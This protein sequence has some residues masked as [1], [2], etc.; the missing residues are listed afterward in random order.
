[1][2]RALTQ[3][4]FSFDGEFFQ[5]PRTCIRPRPRTADLTA[6]MMMAWAS[7]DSLAM[8]ARAGMAPLFTSLHGEESLREGVEA[9]N[10]IRVENGWAPTPSAAN[11][12]VFC[13]EDQEYAQEY[14][15]RFWRSMSGQTIWHYDHL[16]RADWMPGA[17]AEEREALIDQA[18]KAQ[19]AAGIF[20]TPEFVIERIREVQQAGNI[21]HLIT[22]HSFGDMPRDDVERSMRLFAREVLPVIKQIPTQEPSAIPYA[23]WQHSVATAR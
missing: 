1:V 3:E 14:A 17:A 8:A 19:T 20:G 15:S 16:A 9:F 23:E 22:M 18:H 2:R 5:I 4:Y 10:Q 7:A 13:H 6:Q 11:I 12:T 21:G